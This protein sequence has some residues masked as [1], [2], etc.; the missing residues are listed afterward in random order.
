MGYQCFFFI[1]WLSSEPKSFEQILQVF[2]SIYSFLPKKSR[3]STLSSSEALL[4]E[5]NDLVMASLEC[6]FRFW[7]LIEDG[8]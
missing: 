1:V 3:F 2:F 7:G 4:F 8:P 6:S 5:Y